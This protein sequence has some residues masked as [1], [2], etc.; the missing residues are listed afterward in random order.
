MSLAP[1]ADEAARLAEN[2]TQAA[3][4]L[5]ALANERRLLLLCDLVAA[6]ERSVNDLAGTVGLSQSALSQHLA[7]LRD[8]GLV[9]TRRV[10]T[11]IYYR[12]AD[13]KAEAVLKVLHRV[14]CGDETQAGGVSAGG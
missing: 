6:G 7:L 5:R 1:E 3:R 14:F 10:G 2:V 11:T 13:P 4:L 9:A 12:L 8:E